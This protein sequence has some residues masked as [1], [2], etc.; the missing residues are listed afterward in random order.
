MALLT[1]VRLLLALGLLLLLG[2]LGVFIPWRQPNSADD[3]SASSHWQQA[4]QALAQD[5]FVLAKSHFAQCLQ[6]WPLNAEVHFL[7]AQASRRADDPAGWQVN[8]RRAEVLGWDRSSLD[9]ERD[10]MQAQSGDLQRIENRLLNRL[11]SSSGDEELIR[12]ALAKGYLKTDHLD[13]LLALTRTWISH[14]PDHWQPRLFRARALQLLHSVDAAVNEYGRVLELKG[15]HAEAHFE[16]AGALLVN[17]RF[18]EAAAH[19]QRY[20]QSHS[21][22][23]AALVGLANCQLSLG[24]MKAARATL[25]RLFAMHQEGAAG[26]FVRAKIE[27]AEGRPE[28][29]LHWLKKA[30]ARAPHETDITYN[31][32]QTFQQLGN[33]QEAQAYVRKLQDLRQKYEQLERIKTRIRAQPEDLALRDEAG[34]LSLGLGRYE[35]AGRWLGSALQLDPNH[36]PTHQIM[37]EY[38]QKLGK[39]DLAAYHQRKSDG[40]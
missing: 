18:R 22:D 15:D 4:L 31:L 16:L 33:Q 19:F 36:R 28:Q 11:D 38:F 35:E 17:S 20:L 8:F 6:V 2:A 14:Y 12:E 30:E 27:L 5:D 23:S 1:P 39:A 9:L 3:N 25:D 24:E 26:L 32:I 34:A 10:L 37:A 29:A 21:T 7:L 13:A 40:K